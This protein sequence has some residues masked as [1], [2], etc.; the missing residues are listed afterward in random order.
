MARNDAGDVSPDAQADIV[1]CFER[2]TAIH[3]FYASPDLILT[4]LNA[5]ARELL[6][7]PEL[8]RPLWDSATGLLNPDFYRRIG[9]VAATGQE[10]LGSETPFRALDADA[11]PYEIYL[12]VL[13][14]PVFDGEGEIRGVTM[15]ARDL[16]DT[17]FDPYRYPGLAADDARAGNAAA[18][19]T[20][21]LPASLPV[22][23]RAA[24][25]A[26][27]LGPAADV[28]V[29]GDWF[30]TVVRSDGSL[31]LVVGDVVGY[32]VG[33]AAVLG[34]LRAVIRHFLLSG[35]TAAVA[36]VELDRF[37]RHLSGAHAATACIVTLD[38]TTGELDYCTAG[39]QPPLLV[40]AGEGSHFLAPT[41]G[42][43]LGTGSAYAADRD[44]LADGE[45]LLL[46]TDGAVNLT[47]RDPAQAA[48]EVLRTAT[49][50]AHL[51]GSATAAAQRVCARVVE[52]ESHTRAYTRGHGDDIALLAVGRHAPIGPL[53][54][55]LPATPLAVPIGRTAL[56]AWLDTLATS[57]A[58]SAAL[59]HAVGEIVTN[60]VEHAYADHDG[61]RPPLTMEA[62][63]TAIG[64]VEVTVTDRGR[65]RPHHYIAPY[66]GLGL[67]LAG[68]LVDDLAIDRAPTGT[69]VLLRRAVSRPTTM[70][71]PT[72]HSMGASSREPDPYLAALTSA[73]DPDAVLVVSGP[74]DTRTA[75][76]LRDQLRSV[77]GSGTQ[78]RTVDLTAVTILTSA[79]VQVLHEA[80][81]RSRAH[82]EQ[83]TLLAHPGSAAHHIM[84]MTGLDADPP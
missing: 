77:T 72:R 50:A 53:Q 82:H 38:P 36:M 4:A 69:T 54:V 1:A 68:E 40:T 79:G 2:A 44:H 34:Q 59:V 61:P 7:R 60:V 35:A 71:R 75:P 20:A 13:C 11:A 46:Y 65:W 23:P 76:R 22:L 47:H 14:R 17:L 32:G 43:P 45:L 19:Q 24:L 3:A 58:D 74:V 9:E 39:G 57:E 63:L 81:N 62:D 73:D 83:L 66:Q 52:L 21:L 26:T 67:S 84:A 28:A 48:A 27:Y 12:D 51:Y 33:A 15:E 80:R 30:D 5:Q 78:S 41:G 16:T 37:A 18:L 29:G 6:G 8:G 31:G 55:T 49:E 70:A 10:W 25:A 64:C 56:R 42:G